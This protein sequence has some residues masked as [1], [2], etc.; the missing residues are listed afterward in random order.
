M[1]R[2]KPHKAP[3]E[4]LLANLL[5]LLYNLAAGLVGD[6]VSE[7][8]PKLP[9]ALIRNTACELGVLSTL[10]NGAVSLGI[11]DTLGSGF[12]F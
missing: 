6:S 11:E 12:A 5:F 8:T 9:A 7:L 1:V 4:T 2:L 3:N 10:F